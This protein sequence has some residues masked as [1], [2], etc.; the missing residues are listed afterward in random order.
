[1][2]K[3]RKNAGEGYGY[4][5]SGSFAKKA[6]AKRK[7]KSRKGSFVKDVLTNQG[8]RHV[9]L[10]PR[11][12]PV[13]REKKVPVVAP[14][15][16]PTEL[17]VL[18]AN[19]SGKELQ[20][21]KIPLP[22]GG[23]VTIRSNPEPRKNINFGFL[24]ARPTRADLA[25]SRR[26]FKAG[27]RAKVKQ[28]R[29]YIRGLKRSARAARGAQRGGERVFHE[30][31]GQHEDAIVNPA[32]CGKR[33]GGEVCSRKPNHKG[34]CLPQGATMRTRTR[35]PHS[36]QPR[37][38]PDA[39]SLRERF[40]GMPSDGFFVADEPHMPKGDYAQIGTLLALYIKP[41]TGGQV[42]IIKA[43]KSEDRPIVASDE[44]ARQLWFVGGD[45]DLSLSL[46]VFGA[47]QRGAGIWVLGDARRIDYKQRKEHI[48]HPE[49]DEFQHAFG[50]ETGELP[51]VLFDANAKRILLEGGAYSVREEGIVN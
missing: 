19:P 1:M 49:R 10:T 17:M 4:M 48:P 27:V 23:E 9:V 40:T 15:K 44:S 7:E 50:E 2:S 5:F 33:I 14:A 22:G 47:R 32:I 13:K 3:R 39:A 16:N 28:E 31:Y 46:E 29:E 21:I 11:T 38:N 34:P 24:P 18:A 12:N 25:K 8:W 36:W 51:T 26:E 43:A 45:Q 42:Q 6:D 37:T 41:L 35:L 20:E 30:V